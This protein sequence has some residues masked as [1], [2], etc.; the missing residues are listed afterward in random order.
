M[1]LAAKL[2]KAAQVRAEIARALHEMRDAPPEL[3]IREDIEKHFASCVTK[4]IDCRFDEMLGELDDKVMG[5][6]LEALSGQAIDTAL[7]NIF[8]RVLRQ[9]SKAIVEH[10]AKAAVG[11]VPLSLVNHKYTTLMPAMAH[12]SLGDAMA[13]MNRVVE[14]STQ[15]L[16]KHRQFN[17]ETRVLL[18]PRSDG[19]VD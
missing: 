10:S 17:N 2:E 4:F 5:M 6:V 13:H 9:H 18:P 3:N 7:T 12:M 1:P 8:H 16:E 15:E 11:A 19:E 14:Y